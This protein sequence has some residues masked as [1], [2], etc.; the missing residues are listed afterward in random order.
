MQ[1]KHS[2][3]KAFHDQFNNCVDV[4]EHCG[5]TLVNCKDVE[6][7]R[8]VLSLTFQTATKEQITQAKQTAKYKLLGVSYLMC[9]Y[10]SRF[11]KLL[12]D[13]EKLTLLVLTSSWS[14]WMMH[15]IML[16]TGA[17]TQGM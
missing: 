5:G 15:I 3:H 7:E 9:V 1:E 14:L 6:S 12:E 11:G 16:P 13:T 4:I 8:S 17:V 10:Q 2:S